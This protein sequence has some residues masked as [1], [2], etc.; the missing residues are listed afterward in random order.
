MPTKT[1]RSRLTGKLQ[2]YILTEEL[3]TCDRFEV[4]MTELKNNIQT[5]YDTQGIDAQAEKCKHIRAGTYDYVI[6]NTWVAAEPVA[7]TLLIP[8]VLIPLIAKAIIFILGYAAIV[9]IT[10]LGVI[11]IREVVWPAPKY[12]CSICGA[13]P[14]STVAELTAHRTQNHPEAAAHQCPYCGQ[15]FA[16]VEQLNAHVEECPW[17]PSEIPDWVPYA[18]LGLGIIA[19][20]VIVPKVIGYMEKPI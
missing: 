14:F 17:R 13:G 12:Y 19:A 5:E 7:G 15:A 9:V 3:I 4:D 6:V 1:M 11:A 8:V 16:T 20:I 2:T 18:L 10:Y